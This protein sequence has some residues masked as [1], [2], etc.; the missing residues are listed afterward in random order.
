MKRLVLLL[1][2]I[3]LA[4]AGCGGSNAQPKDDPGAF[5]VKVV[6]QIVHNRYSAAWNDL[7]P[8]D[9]KV[10]PS[11]EYVQCETRSPVLSAPTTTKVLSVS[12]ESVGIG[13]GSFVDSKAVHVRLGF[14]GGFHLVH[15]VHV[16][17]ANGKWTWILPPGRFRDYK[18][19]KCPI[20]A[21]STE[22][23][24]TS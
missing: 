19:D 12:S 22:P 17:A 23:P 8:A 18:A 21:G 7:H 4:V 14:P 9:Q 5:A 3:G 20:D 2:A 10:A 1:A 15:T 6:D 24:S 16:V 11:A 13:N